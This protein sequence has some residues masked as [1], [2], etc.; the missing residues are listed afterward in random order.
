MG[1]LTPLTMAQPRN[2]CVCQGWLQKDSGEN[3]GSAC[4][5]QRKGPRP[6]RHHGANGT[7][8]RFAPTPC[9]HAPHRYTGTK[10]RCCAPAAGAR[11][12]RPLAAGS[13][14]AADTPG[15]KGAEASGG[16]LGPVAENANAASGSVL[17]LPAA[18]PLPKCL[19]TQ[20]HY[21]ATLLCMTPWRKQVT[22]N[23]VFQKQLFQLW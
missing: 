13:S 11:A 12:L 9:R 15:C 2:P 8:L 17:G 5:V 18:P 23:W 19:A 14:L 20:Q 16:G 6:R 7:S 10:W 22:Y 3:C 21:K 4:H 1:G